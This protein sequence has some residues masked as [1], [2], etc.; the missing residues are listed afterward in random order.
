MAFTHNTAKGAFAITAGANALT[1]KADSLYCGDGGTVTVVTEN[2]DT[3]TFLSV[4]AGSI[5]PVSV[6]KVT[7]GTNIIGLTA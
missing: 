4:P 3:V 7:S 6:T 1:K 5:L 2:G